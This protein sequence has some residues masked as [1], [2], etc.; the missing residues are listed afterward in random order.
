MMELSVSRIEDH[1]GFAYYQSIFFFWYSL[2]GEFAC[3]TEAASLRMVRVFFLGTPKNGKTCSYVKKKTC[4]NLMDSTDE[5]YVVPPM[6]LPV[7]L[8]FVFVVS[9]GT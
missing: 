8:F 1:S 2:M 6:C 4:K 7:V 3:T 9:I 5:A